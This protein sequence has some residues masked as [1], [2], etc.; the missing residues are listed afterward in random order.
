MIL[1]KLLLFWL[2]DSGEK[3]F[4]QKWSELLISRRLN[5][6]IP[7]KKEFIGKSGIVTL[8]KKKFTETYIRKY[9]YSCKV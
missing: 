5:L 6:V 3:Y 1:V 8:V 4:R 9:G 2:S 7:S